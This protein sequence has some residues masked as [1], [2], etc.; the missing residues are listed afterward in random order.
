MLRLSPVLIVLLSL[1]LWAGPSEKEALDL[2]R[3]EALSNSQVMQIASTIT[4]EFGPRLTNSP[5]IKKA[6]AW[7]ETTLKS[8]QLDNVALEEW[9]PFGCGW[10]NERC[11]VDMLEPTAGTLIACPKAWTP[12]TQ[13]RLCGEAVWIPKSATLSDLEQYH[14]RLAGKHVLISS[15][16][17]LRPH[18]TP[19]A[20]RYTDEELARLG[21]SSDELLAAQYDRDDDILQFFASENVASLIDCSRGDDGTLF[22][23]AGGSRD[24]LKRTALPQIVLATEHYN[25]IMRLLSKK[26]PVRL[27]V[28]LTNKFHDEITNSFNIIGEIPGTTKSD[29]VVMLGAH[30]DSWHAATGATDNAAGSAVMLE[31]MR[32]LK[33][34][35]LKMPRTVRLALWTGEEQGLLGSAAYV[36]KHYDELKEKLSAYYNID[37]GAGKI[38]GIYLQ[39]NQNV[40]PIFAPWI[41]SFRDLGMTTIS[42]K[43]T[44]Y[45]DHMSFDNAGFPGFQFIQDPLDYF[46]RTHHSN[47]DSYE[48]LVAEDLKQMA[49]VVASFVYLTASNAD[50][51][52]R[53]D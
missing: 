22:V 6:A 9:G 4:D 17:E 51:L 7:V 12:G 11:S 27:S 40:A 25:R 41:E 5:N 34:T 20:R 46:S 16:K 53:K 48:R 44:L 36:K 32:I 10:S 24:P 49:A 19:D 45:T 39:E 3:V 15:Q 2:I 37:N 42:P 18:F 29:E 38:R 28:D 30:F 1:S 26:I 14:G 43:N 33:K 21:A 23:A 35:G 50:L 8:W 52:P 13:G 47:M 31:A